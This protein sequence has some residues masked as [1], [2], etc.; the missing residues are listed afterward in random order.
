MLVGRLGVIAFLCLAIYST[1][2]G[3][4]EFIFDRLFSAAIIFFSLRV[5][6]KTSIPP[7]VMYFGALVLISHHLKLY[8]NVYAGIPFDH[9]IHFSAG[10][11]LG[12][13]LYG[14][15]AKLTKSAALGIALAVLVSAG[16]G[17]ML[18]IVEF[19]GYSFLGKGE[20]ILFYGSG[21]WGEWNNISWDLISNTFGAI[22]GSVSMAARRVRR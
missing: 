13:A 11:F 17:T 19:T 16:L 15:F 6:K 8:G 9:W 5:Y 10:L 20:G 21:D 4:V 3:D 18:E 1:V 2:T 7:A 14:Y 12:L 22:T